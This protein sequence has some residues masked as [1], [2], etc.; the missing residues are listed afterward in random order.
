MMLFDLD[1]T[2]IRSYMERVDKRYDVVELL[3]GVLER[4]EELDEDIAIVTNQGSVA[5]GYQSEQDV[6][7]KLKRV[8]SALDYFNISLFTE[9]FERYTTGIDGQ[10]AMLPIYVCYSDKRSPDPRYQDARRRKPSGAMITEALRNAGQAAAGSF[11]VGDREE[12]KQAA[13][14]AGVGFLWAKDFFRWGQ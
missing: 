6:I 12:D 10:Y 4:L 13:A 8:G 7:A 5:F 3:P 1:G 11:Y 2:L 14:D 9:T